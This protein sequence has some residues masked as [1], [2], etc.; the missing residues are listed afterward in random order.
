MSCCFIIFIYAILSGCEMREYLSGAN[1][2]QVFRL[3]WYL[4]FIQLF[5]YLL[6]YF[7]YFVHPQ[8]FSIYIYCAASVIQIALVP[9]SSSVSI[10][11]PS[12]YSVCFGTPSVPVCFGTPFIYSVCI[13]IYPHQAFS[14]SVFVR[15]QSL[16]DP[17][18][19]V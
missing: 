14:S 2:P 11:V 18:L 13:R 16:V 19:R 6:S 8:Y 15:A 7:S 9:L 10:L 5:R 3:F 1:H 12:V 4:Q 17:D